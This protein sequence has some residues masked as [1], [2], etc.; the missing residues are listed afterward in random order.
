[1]WVGDPQM[2]EIKFSSHKMGVAVDIKLGGG[3]EMKQPLSFAL[4][5]LSGLRLE[6]TPYT[7]LHA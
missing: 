2:T 1:M 6:F 4:L 5:S 3:G 7:H